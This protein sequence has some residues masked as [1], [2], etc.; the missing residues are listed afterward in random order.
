MPNN[1]LT[2]GQELA[3]RR[4]VVRAQITRRRPIENKRDPVTDTPLC[5]GDIAHRIEHRQDLRDADGGNGHVADHWEDV[6]PQALGP[7]L[8]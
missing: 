8:P 7:L 5:H 4:V 2:C 6:L 1:L 3:T